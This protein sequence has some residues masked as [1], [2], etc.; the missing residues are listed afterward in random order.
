MKESNLRTGATYRGKTGNLFVLFRTFHPSL[1][2]FQRQ[3]GQLHFGREFIEFE[4][5][6]QIIDLVESPMVN[7]KGA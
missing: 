1:E 4:N 3:D 5:G 7:E 6:E 2:C